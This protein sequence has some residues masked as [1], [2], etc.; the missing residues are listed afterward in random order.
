MSWDVPWD[1]PNS[2]TFWPLYHM[3]RSGS[4][5]KS[6]RGIEGR[7]AEQ[8]GYAVAVR[9]SGVRPTSA[10]GQERPRILV[11]PNSYLD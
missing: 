9:Y 6:S 3:S 4:G 7:H 2:R 1:I 11:W 10:W 8:G 5:S